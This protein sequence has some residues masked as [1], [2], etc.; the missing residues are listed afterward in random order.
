MLIA[1]LLLSSE[2]YLATYT[3]SCFS[4]SQGLF[5]PTE[6]RLLLIAGNLALLRTPYATIFGHKLLLFDVGGAIAAAAMFAM[7]IAV[8]LRHTAQLYR[9]EPLP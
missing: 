9:Q 3:L 8:T 5:G 1:F 6:I 7:A 4:L 2:S